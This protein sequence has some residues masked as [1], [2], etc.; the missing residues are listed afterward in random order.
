MVGITLRL[1]ALVVITSM[2]SAVAHTAGETCDR[3]CLSV[4]TDQFLA[5][6][7]KQDPSAVPLAR[8]YRATENG[9]AAGL[10]MMNAFATTTAVGSKFYVIDPVSHQVFFVSELKEGQTPILFWG[11]LK[12]VEGKFEEIELFNARSRSDG[13]YQ[14]SAKQVSKPAS[15]WLEK[16]DR[17][18]IANRAQLLEWGR[19]SFNISYPTPP[20]DP[21]C[22]IMENG[23][24][25]E[26]DSGVADF[27]SE[28][29]KKPQAAKKMVN[30]PCGMSNDR[31][32]DPD[33]RTDIIDEQQGITVSFAVVHGMVEPSYVENPTI[34]AFVP[35]TILPPYLAL[36]EKWKGSEQAKLPALVPMPAAIQV[37]EMH[38]YYDGKLQGF[39]ML[40][41]LGP[42]GAHSP[43]VS[44]SN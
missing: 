38:R 1:A 6:V 14:F 23:K 3:T 25:V 20:T 35:N 30:I 37:A 27:V 9:V 42:P 10:P 26:E 18:R 5:A 7:I 44:K 19:S 29:G 33:A 13:G 34:S 22:L 17:S 12:I 31:P 15:Q 28:N 2:A 8:A 43:W 39:Y 16:V 36:L 4:F 24:I 41:R 32:T 21:A 40:L 11:R